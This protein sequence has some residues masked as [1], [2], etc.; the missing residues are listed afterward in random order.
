MSHG[1]QGPEKKRYFT[2]FNRSQ[3]IQHVV[4]IASFSTLCFTGLLQK[5]SDSDTADTVIQLLGGV[6]RLRV[7]HR[8]TAIV[9]MIEA[10]YHVLEIG[11][12]LLVK[13]VKPNMI[14]N[15]K[16]AKDAKQMMLFFLGIKKERARCD[17]FDFRQKTEYLS[18]IWGSVVMIATGLMMW[19]PI[20]TT[21]FLP[22]EFIPAARVAHGGEGLLAFLA[23]FIWHM[24]SAHVAPEVFP[25][26]TTMFTGKISEERMMHEHPLEYERLMEA[27]R[28]GLAAGGW[29]HIQQPETELQHDP[30]P[31]VSAVM[32]SRIREIDPVPSYVQSPREQ[33]L[34]SYAPAIVYAPQPMA[35]Q[36]AAHSYVTELS[37]IQYRAATDTVAEPEEIVELEDVEY[38]DD[39]VDDEPTDPR[40][41]GNV[42]G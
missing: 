21:T 5:F 27:E 36:P 10:V 41:Y 14:P 31:L 37:Q 7:I 11:W 20:Q 34:Q 19:Y 15:L 26:D 2:R 32:H 40:R 28:E 3:R 6:E 24:Y 42:R 33:P 9:F 38:L 22:G 4:Q 39:E 1:S 17:R 18:L 16:D 35:Q 30:E 13:R 25:F 29:P 8:V 12:L 23:I